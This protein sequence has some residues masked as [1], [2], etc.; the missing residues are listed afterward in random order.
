MPNFDHPAS[1]AGNVHLLQAHLNQ[2]RAGQ[3]HLD[4]LYDSRLDDRNFVPDGM[5]PGLR[6]MPSR[7]RQNG[8]I[9]SDIPDESV[10]FNVQRGSA[11][12]YQGAMHLQH[13][14][15]GR[16]VQAPQFRGGP[17]PNPLAAAQRLPPGLA[18]LGGRPPHDP[19]Q[20]MNSSM[21]IAN[22]VMPGSLHGNV[23]GQQPFGNYQQAAGL[24]FG[25]GPQI[26]MPHPTAQQLQS[27]L[28]HNPLQGLVHPSN[29]GTS[30]AQVLGGGGGLPGNLRG[31]NAAF[32]QHPQQMRQLHQLQQQLP[33]QMLPHM[34]PGPGGPSSQSTH[35][36]MALLMSG[37][38]R[39]GE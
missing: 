19:N 36:L 32:G 25:G 27:S 10:P 21:G 8:A 2:Q 28:A 9:F 37:S 31:A 35:D 20:F 39:P 12:M 1:H 16:S 13:A 17:S 7:G 34:L 38:R 18:N 14:S 3:G 5:V 4:S 22:G 29:L 23:P 33:P 26:R 24:G 6:P 11:Q 15:V 30:Q